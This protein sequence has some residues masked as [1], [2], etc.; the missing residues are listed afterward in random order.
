MIT[1]KSS[2]HLGL[3]S[4]ND[5]VARNELG[6]NTAGGLNTKC[7]RVDVNENDIAER[8]ITR[9]DTTLDGSTI[10]DSLVGVDTLR[11]L[12]AE[13]LLQELLNLGNTSGTTDKNDLCALLDQALP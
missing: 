11:G 13:V 6:H 1:K 5:G 8:L 2:L 3:A 4:G 7:E 10:R 9:E 12:L